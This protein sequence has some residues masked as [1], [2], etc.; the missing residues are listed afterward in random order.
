MDCESSHR[1]MANYSFGFDA[2]CEEMALPPEPEPLICGKD[3]IGMG[4]TPGPRMGEILHSVADAVLEKEVN[5]PAEAEAHVR[6][7]FPL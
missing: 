4:Y 7:H 2:W 5:T 1:M 6:R 3:L